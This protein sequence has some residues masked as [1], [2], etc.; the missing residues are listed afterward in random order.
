M[1]NKNKSS[2]FPTLKLSGCLFEFWVVKIKP[3]T[4]DRKVSLK[5]QWWVGFRCC[6]PLVSS[7]LLIERQ[8]IVKKVRDTTSTQAAR[9]VTVTVNLS[10]YVSP[11]WRTIGQGGA[12][13]NQSG[14][15]LTKM[16]RRTE[17]PEPLTLI[18]SNLSSF[19][20]SS[21]LHAASYPSPDSGWMLASSLLQ[22]PLW[23][24]D[25]LRRLSLEASRFRTAAFWH[26]Q[27]FKAKRSSSSLRRL[28][29]SASI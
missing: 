10:V 14:V 19:S 12:R 6:W 27:Q 21:S 18:C 20:L 15:V 2:W 1:D 13:V 9:R 29:P 25:N 22:G 26:S 16:K 8:L 3:L 23:G 7:S 17:A 11:R 24:S 4:L 28:L 5:I